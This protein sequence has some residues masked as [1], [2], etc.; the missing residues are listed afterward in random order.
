MREL[1]RPDSGSSLCC[2]GTVLSSLA[3]GSHRA[4][5]QTTELCDPCVEGIRGRLRK[6]IAC[7][8]ISCVIAWRKR[9]RIRA[10]FDCSLR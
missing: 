1:S 10:S 3:V 7:G 4:V 8:G 9:E 2:R 5:M 6:S